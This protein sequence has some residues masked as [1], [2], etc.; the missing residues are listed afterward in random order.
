MPEGDFS[1]PSFVLYINNARLPGEREAEIKKIIILDRL[2]APSTFA[3][4]ASDPD[5][6]W[7]ENDDY[8]IGS[9]VKIL[10]GYKDGM[11][12]LMIGDITGLSCTYK[13]NQA[14][15]VI[16]TGQNLVHRLKRNIKNQ[17]FSEVTV[18]DI[19]S[20]LAD[21]AGLSADV[22]DLTYEHP[23]TLQNQK[24]DYEY[25][26]ILAE[27][28]DCYFSVND[29]T[30][31]FNRLEKNLSE[32]VVLEYGKT[33]LEFFPEAD[34]SKII[35]E[36]EVFAWNPAKHEVI[37]GTSTAKDI[38]AAGGAVIDDQFGGAK[39]IHIDQYALDQEGADQCA[40]DL[41]TRNTRD[42]VKGRGSTFGNPDIH[43]GSIVKVEGIGEKFSGKYF[44]LSALHQLIPLEG[45]KT[46]FTFT[47]TLGSPSRSGNGAGAAQKEPA[48]AGAAG[49]EEAEEKE[50]DENPEITG[51]KW[52]KD[53]EEVTKANV[54]DVVMI[55]AE[56]RNIDDGTNVSINIWEKDKVG[57]DD[58]IKRF[59]GI[60]KDNK[61]EKEWKVE[62]H[63]DTDD[64][65]SED[66]EKEKGYTLPEYVFIIETSTGPE[67]K[68]EES[69]V[70]E[71]VDWIEIKLIDHE[72]E[73]P[74]ANQKFSLIKDGEKVAEGTT[75]DEGYLK[76]E[77]LNPGHFH[78]V[79]DDEK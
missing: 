76:I 73:E 23:F 17:A 22:E 37:T 65:E 14:T 35:S 42:Y 59:S 43:G 15:Q 46:S 11:G 19:I 25:L 64:L 32:D 70:L 4:H 50:E 62:Y 3:I 12:E 5:G 54:E 27:R 57:S 31:R 2:N 33:L 45:Y 44:I 56:T 24:S 60:V 29:T 13:R 55:T 68:S 26:Q 28:Y 69:P 16:I 6:E 53:G 61:I 79:L 71:V 52:M 10:M 75:D 39:T 48:A 7:R 78:I 77:D 38:D 18:K 51:L 67:V 58:F 8:F 63:E 47:T 74:I 36:V 21:G 30:L 41:L 20:Q 72:T 1:T 9:R 34:T 66:E 40:I 49:E